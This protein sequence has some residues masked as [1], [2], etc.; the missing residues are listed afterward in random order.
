MSQY[1]SIQT[2]FPPPAGAG[3]PL[4]SRHVSVAPFFDI[5]LSIRKL[6]AT[7]STG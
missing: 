3:A 1:P 2:S 6:K 5:F 4:I 7:Q